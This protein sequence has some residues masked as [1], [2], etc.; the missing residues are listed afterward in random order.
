MPPLAQA[1]ECND[2]NTN[3]GD[4]C[5]KFN[6]VEAYYDCPEIGACSYRA[7]CGDGRLEAYESCD[8]AN[9]QPQDGCS[10]LCQLEVPERTGA[11]R[12]SGQDSGVTTGY[13]SGASPVSATGE[14]MAP[15]A[16]A[17]G[18]YCGNGIVEGAENCDDG[19]NQD[20][21]LG[22]GHGCAPGCKFPHFCGDGL[23][24][25]R[26]GEGCDDGFNPGVYGYCQPDCQAAPFCGDLIVQEDQ[27][28]RC[29]DALSAHCRDC[30]YVPVR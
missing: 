1:A 28:E 16:A 12:T 29:E 9:Q 15:D 18:G 27:G 21:Y 7:I 8:D 23:I 4:G 20:V 17:T 5:S 11:G 25:G 3:A 2:G 6:Q 30:R 22:D 14:L 19:V 10:A 13:D 26:F 24:D